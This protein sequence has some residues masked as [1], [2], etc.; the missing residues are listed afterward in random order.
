MKWAAEGL[1]GNVKM[2]FD[3]TARRL[4]VLGIPSARVY[5]SRYVVLSSCLVVVV[6]VLN[7]APIVT[8]LS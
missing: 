2:L 5:G 8:W 1:L 6:E 7:T 3:D 4:A